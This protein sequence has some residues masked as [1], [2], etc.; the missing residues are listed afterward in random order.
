[1]D[2]SMREMFWL[3]SAGMLSEGDRPIAGGWMRKMTATH[4]ST[5]GALWVASGN[6]S[7]IRT[8]HLQGKR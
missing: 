7:F 3:H 4:C 5:S 6:L 2:P 8:V 1:M